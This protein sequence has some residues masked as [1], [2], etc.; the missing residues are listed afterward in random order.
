MMTQPLHV[1]F[2]ADQMQQ[3]VNRLQALSIPRR[4]LD[5]FVRYHKIRRTSEQNKRLQW[6]C[7]SHAGWLN[8]ERMRLISEGKL[9]NYWPETDTDGVRKHIFNPLY[10][11]T[12]S[13]TKPSK[14]DM[15]DILTRYE[16]DLRNQGIELPENESLQQESW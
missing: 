11:G 9:P 16:A 2:N 3:A 7:R 14:L 1:V 5:I 13:S 15:M 10:C 12:D 8:K 4:G 6:L